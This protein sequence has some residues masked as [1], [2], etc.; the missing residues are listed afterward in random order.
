MDIVRL[1]CVL[2]LEVSVIL[3]VLD[4]VVSEVEA[5]RHVD[6]ISQPLREVHVAKTP[7]ALVVFV[8]YQLFEVIEIEICFVPEILEDIFDSDVPI[9]VTIQ[10]QKGFTDRL[11]AVAELCFQPGF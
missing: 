3:G 1:G 8:D 2:L 4:R 10:S 11:E 6:G 9:I 7:L 5:L